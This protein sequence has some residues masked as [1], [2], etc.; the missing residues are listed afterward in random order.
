MG[1]LSEFQS[2][3]PSYYRLL[4]RSE[5]MKLLIKASQKIYIQLELFIN[6]YKSKIVI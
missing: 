3:Y 1:I 5:F 6:S 2:T 4:P